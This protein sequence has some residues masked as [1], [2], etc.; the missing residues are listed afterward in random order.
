[1]VINPTDP[2]LSIGIAA[3]KLGVSTQ[4]LKKYEREGLIITYKSRS[5]QRL[6]SER[7]LEW[8]DF[9]YRQ[10]T[11]NNMKIAGLRLLL[12]LIPCW[13]IK[14]KGSPSDCKGG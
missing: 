8:L 5:G 12:A 6:Y 4:L 1:M 7:D 3:N 2:I 10:T 11:E 13:N 14:S 9:L